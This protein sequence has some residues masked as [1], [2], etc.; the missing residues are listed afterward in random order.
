MLRFG[1]TGEYL[2]GDT[3]VAGGGGQSGVEYGTALATGVDA[4]GFKL[5]PKVAIDTSGEWG[6]SK[7][8]PC[9]RVQV[10]GDTLSVLVAPASCVTRETFTLPKAVNN[11]T[12]IVGVWIGG[13][14]DVIK[15]QTFVFMA[16]GK[17]AMLDPLGDTLGNNC[18]GPGVEYGSYTDSTSTKQ[19]KVVGVTRDTNGCAGFSDAGSLDTF[20]LT[21]SADGRTGVLTAGTSNFPVLRVSN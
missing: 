21:I 19:L 20:S 1:S 17:Y 9:T 10:K 18:G 4:R 14:T 12:G 6:L 8:E 7:L 3:G 16:N 13:T 15:T 2:L 11:P 5:V